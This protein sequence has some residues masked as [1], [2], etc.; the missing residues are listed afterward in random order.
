MRGG[1]RSLLDCEVLACGY[2]LMPNLELAGVLGCAIEHGAVAVDRWQQT[3]PPAIFCAGEGTGIG[4]VDLAL[5]EG[6]IAGRAAVGARA[7]DAQLFAERARWHA[8]AARLARAFVLRPELRQ[9]CDGSN[10]RTIVCRCED[11]SHGEL[12]QHRSWRSAKL[13]TRCGMGPC[14]GRICGPASEFL[15]EWQAESV[16]PPIFPAR[17]ESVGRLVP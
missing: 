5:A 6:N 12:L 16:R 4:G 2:G 9:L 11:V 15:F 8:F 17:V 13:H 3:S 1:K 10:A 14:Q 7:P